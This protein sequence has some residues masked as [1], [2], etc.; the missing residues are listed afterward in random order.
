[1]DALK[2]NKLIQKKLLEISYGKIKTCVPL[3][4]WDS[5][6]HVGKFFLAHIAYSN[7]FL[8]SKRIKTFGAKKADTAV[9]ELMHLNRKSS[10]PEKRL[11]TCSHTCAVHAQQKYGQRRPRRQGDKINKV[12]WNINGMTLRQKSNHMAR[13][14]EQPKKERKKERL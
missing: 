8:L 9:I 4:T 11:G 6:R 3:V 5:T 10:S 2:T 14:R 1:M 12:K 7:R 13:Q